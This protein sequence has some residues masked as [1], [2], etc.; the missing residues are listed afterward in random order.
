MERLPHLNDDEAVSDVV[1]SALLVGITV[2]LA[3]AMAGLLFAL[4]P[5]QATPQSNLAVSVSPGNQAWGTGDEQLVVT[6]LG[7]DPLAQDTTIVSYSLNGGA[8]V[9]ITGAA[10]GF[11]GGRLSVGER[12][13]RTVPLQS[14]DRVAINVVNTEGASTLLATAAVVPGAVTAGAACPFDTSPPTAAWT[15]APVDLTIGSGAS[16]AVTVTMDLTDDCAGVDAMQAPFS[17]VPAP[18][19]WASVTPAALADLGAMA[20]AAGLTTRWTGSIPAPGG[21]GWAAK[22]GQT[23][24]YYAAGVT[25]RGGNVGSTPVRTDFIDILGA[26]TP[27]NGQTA[28]APTTIT[29]P[30]NVNADDGALANVVEGASAAALVTLNPD[31]V[32]LTTGW[33]ASSGT[34]LAAIQ[35]SDNTRD[36]TTTNLGGLRVQF[37]NVV[38]IGPVTQ[39]QVQLEQSIVRYSN[40]GWQLQVCNINPGT[41]GTAFPATPTASGVVAAQSNPNDVQL[42]FDITAQFPPGVSAWDA[43]TLSNLEVMVLPA[44]VGSK[45]N[46]GGTSSWRVDRVWVEVGSSAF[47]A[48]QQFDWAGVVPLSVGG[49]YYLQLEYSGA[50]EAFDVRVWDWT[51]NSYNTGRAT[52]SGAGTVSVFLAATEVAVGTR[53]VR[54]RL[55]DAGADTLQTSLG[56]DFVRVVSAP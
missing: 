1:G 13:T 36:S 33:T 34:V 32:P 30:A 49:T 54:I 15:Q 50:N 10:L 22:G 29:S 9:G 56:L 37:S 6:H 27:P 20:P 28:V 21:G 44:Q 3:V 45:D 17:A 5:P 35:A 53:D 12:W 18:H 38:S 47:T 14:T 52:L 48:T 16:G 4:P 43:T 31:G 26:V 55:V 39:V 51:G 40:D 25:D 11:S 41:C 2:L 7:G 46:N 42:T 8:P 23:L 19:L 24:Q